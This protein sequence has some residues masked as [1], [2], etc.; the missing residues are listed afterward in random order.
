MSRLNKLLV[1]VLLL[2]LASFIITCGGGGGGGTAAYYEDADGDGYGNPD[3]FVTD[4]PPDGYVT[5]GADCDDSDPDIHP[6]AVEIYGDGIDNNCDGAVIDM[7]YRDGDGDG[8]GNPDA[9]VLSSSPT[10]GYVTDNTDC[11]DTDISINPGAD[12][13]LSDQKDNDCDGLVDEY[14][15][16]RDSDGD[17]YGNPDIAL[18]AE[19]PPDGYVTDNTD[20]DDTNAGINPG[21]TEIIGDWID[22][23]CNGMIDEIQV[24][25]HYLTIQEAIDASSDGDTVLVDDGTYG[26]NINFNGKTITLTSANGAES[27]TINGRLKG[28][29]VT[30]SSREGEGTILDGF[31]ITE[32]SG[33][34][35]DDLYLFG[36]GIYCID[37]SP[38][39]RNCIITNNM[40]SKPDIAPRGG[41]IYCKSSSITLT[42]CTISDNSITVTEVDAAEFDAFQ[43]NPRGGGIYCESSSLT[44]T[45]C[46]ISGNSSVNEYGGYFTETNALGG[47]IS[48]DRYGQY[49]SNSTLVITNCTIIDN[50]AKSTFHFS[51]GGGISSR[52]S[53][54]TLIDSTIKGNTAKGQGSVMGGGISCNSDSTITNC[55]IIDNSALTGFVTGT[56]GGGGIYGSPVIT[57]SIISGNASSDCG[58]GIYGAPTITNSIITGNTA[59]RFGGGI[60][61]G[62]VIKNSIISGNT[63]GEGGGM[64]GAYRVTN[65]TIYGNTALEKGGGISFINSIAAKVANC[66]ITGNTSG[67]F[68]GGIFGYESI[69]TV[70]NS[71]MRGNSAYVEGN[72]I[73]LEHFAGEPKHRDTVANVYYSNINSDFIAGDEYASWTVE[74]SFTAEPLFVDDTDEDLSLRDYHL[75]INSPCIDAGT[76]EFYFYEEN[77]VPADDIDGDERDSYPDIG[78][79]EYTE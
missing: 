7:Y 62:G 64:Y 46:V 44:L 71:I 15:Y 38:T 14:I 37:S 56:T 43:S 47:G 78:S 8:Y 18:E 22:Q 76:D 26:E 1:T 69:V 9:S 13:V 40:I 10:A 73:Y 59:K 23:N 48:S 51:G 6:G 53:S 19:S 70:V 32:G 72:E 42:G 16:Y 20:C 35:I 79:D 49:G 4:A 75:Q 45:D 2:F 34:L 21:M 63:A 41:G 39:I 30:F 31:T 3:V 57:N 28:T 58:G 36:G 77:I 54:L 50:L 5:N 60:F 17:G 25:G 33:T 65:C 29:V 27:T 61:H 52:Y 68:G 74:N 66:T 12:E 55:I 67:Y 11:D 24:P